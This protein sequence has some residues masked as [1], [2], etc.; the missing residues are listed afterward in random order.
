MGE[1]ALPEDRARED[2]S[3][4]DS[5]GTVVIGQLAEV[6]DDAIMLSSGTVISLPPGMSAAEFPVGA[7]VKVVATEQEGRIVA[8][9]I[10]RIHG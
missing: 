2:R 4:G 9:Q 3:P 6:R 8:E 7:V 10:D 5:A 1:A